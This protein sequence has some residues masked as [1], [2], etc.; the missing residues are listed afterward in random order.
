MIKW[1]LAETTNMSMFSFFLSFLW[2][3]YKKERENVCVRNRQT[4]LFCFVVCFIVFTKALPKM[5]AFIGFMGFLLIGF[6]DCNFEF[7]F[8]ICAHVWV[9]MS[10]LIIGHG[11]LLSRSTSPDTASRWWDTRQFYFFGCL[12]CEIPVSGLRWLSLFMYMLLWTCLSF[13]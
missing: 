9:Y 11:P 6:A 4:Q 8:L 7:I 3:E 12:I 5:L 10:K 2:S 1:Y 13:S